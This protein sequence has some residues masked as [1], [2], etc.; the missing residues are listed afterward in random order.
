M[1]FYNIMSKYHKFM[2]EFNRE[3]GYNSFYGSNKKDF[4]DAW[5]RTKEPAVMDR[6]DI[7]RIEPPKPEEPKPKK[8]M[9]EILAEQVEL[10][11]QREELKKPI[12]IELIKADVAAL[13]PVSEKKQEEFRKFTNLVGSKEFN[14]T[15]E[16]AIKDMYYDQLGGLFPRE[17]IYKDK[18][19]TLSQKNQD[20]IR[21][22]V[23]AKL[24]KDLSK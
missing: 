4:L 23:R 19:L 17:K 10:K 24:L 11:R 13:P 9:R 7:N 22:S 15:I 12:P 6:E 16:E 8:T 2:R 21:A 3:K 18:F 14:D 20:K 5:A 1:L